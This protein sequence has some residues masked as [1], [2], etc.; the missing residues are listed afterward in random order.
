MVIAATSDPASGSDNA[1]PVSCVPPRGPGSQR[2]RCSGVPNKVIAPRAQPLHREGEIGQRSVAGQYL[3]RQTER[4]QVEAD[5]LPRYGEIEPAR[6]AQC[7]HEPATGGVE[8]AMIAEQRRQLRRRPCLQPG[9]ELAV[10]VLEPRPS[11]IFSVAQIAP[12]EK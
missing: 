7:R 12:S 5:I 11:E 4:A 8:I 3:S 2:A 1:K 6:I 10:T 9:R